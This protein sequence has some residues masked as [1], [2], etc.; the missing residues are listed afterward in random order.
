MGRSP[1]ATLPA[2]VGLFSSN[3]RKLQKSSLFANDSDF[4]YTLQLLEP[5]KGLPPGTLEIIELNKKGK[6]E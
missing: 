5:E 3:E 1:F 6:L 4:S 2:Q